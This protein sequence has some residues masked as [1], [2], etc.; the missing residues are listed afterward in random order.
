MNTYLVGYDLDKPGQDYADLIA[1]LEGFG[2]WWHHLDSTWIIK[3]DLTHIQIRDELQ[4]H[5][6]ANDKL[7]VVNI[8]GDAAAWRGFNEKGA[9]WLKENI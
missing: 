9:K 5:I 2:T 3:S 1:R 4:K 7:L 6:D 8:T